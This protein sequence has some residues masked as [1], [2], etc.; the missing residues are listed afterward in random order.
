MK[1]QV[2]GKPEEISE[3]TTVKAFLDARGI[4]P[5]VVAC[6][7]NLD[8]VRRAKLADVVLKEGDSLEILQMIGG[9]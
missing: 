3:G 8:I 2:N 9:G 4:N 7:L 5:N 6:E 1:V